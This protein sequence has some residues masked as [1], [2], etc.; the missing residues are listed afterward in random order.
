MSALLNAQ[1]IL[2]FELLVNFSLPRLNVLLSFL[3]FSDKNCLQF[4]EFNEVLLLKGLHNILRIKSSSPGCISLHAD[5]APQICLL[6][7]SFTA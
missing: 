2:I 7:P 4:L 1:L 6:Y 3:F 5:L